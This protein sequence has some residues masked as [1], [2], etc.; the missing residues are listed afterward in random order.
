M[1]VEHFILYHCYN[2]WSADDATKIAILIIIIII[3]IGCVL[4]D[5]DFCWYKLVNYN[6]QTT[7][8][9]SLIALKQLTSHTEQAHKNR[10]PSHL[11]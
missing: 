11:R 3:I 10:D 4:N 6:Q 9:N 7:G 8:S 1:I 5:C 2:L